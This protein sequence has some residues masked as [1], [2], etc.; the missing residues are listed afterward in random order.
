LQRKLVPEPTE[1]APPTPPEV[2]ELADE[3][4][5]PDA[6]VPIVTATVVA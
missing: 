2:P 3:P 1:D 5:P 4:V 6:V